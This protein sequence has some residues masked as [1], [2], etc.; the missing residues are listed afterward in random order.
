MIKI[1][2]SLIFTLFIGLANAQQLE[3]AKVIGNTSTEVCESTVV[4]AAGNIYSIGFFGGTVDFDSGAPVNELISAGGKDVYILKLDNAGEY[5]WAKSISSSGDVMGFTI[6]VGGISNDEIYIGGTFEGMADFDSNNPGTNTVTSQGLTDGFILK[7]NDNGDFQWVKEYGSFGNEAIY[8]LKL[9]AANQLYS[10]GAFENTINFNPGNTPIDLI[11]NPGGTDVFVMKH[12]ISDNLMWVKRFGGASYNDKGT[13]ITFD[14][15][16]NVIVAGEFEGTGNFDPVGNFDMISNG[17]FDVFI[18]KFAHD[19]DWLWAKNIGGPLNELDPKIEANGPNDIYITGSYQGTADFDPSAAVNNITSAGAHDIYVATLNQSG[20]LTAVESFGGTGEDYSRGID[21]S[22]TNEVYI[23]GD[24]ESTVNFNNAGGT[25]ELTSAGQNDAFVLKLNANLSIDWAK[26]FGGISEQKAQSIYVDNNN[27]VY[28]SGFAKGVTDF[29]PFSGITNIP[30]SSGSID[31]FIMK[32]A[33]C[34]PVYF[35]DAQSDCGSYTWTN[36]IEYT[37]DNSVATQVFESST[38]CDSIVILNLEVYPLPSVSAGAN[39]STCLGDNSTLS[40]TGAISYTWD[41]IDDGLTPIDGNG[42]IKVVP[43]SFSYEVTG[44]A[45]NGC[46]NVDTV[47][48]SIIPL[49]TFTVTPINTTC[50][51]LT[52]GSLTLSGLNSNASYQLVY[53][54]SVSGTTNAGSI[55][56]NGSGQIIV[57]GLAAEVFTNLTITSQLTGCIGTD[58]GSYTINDATPITIVQEPNIE[59]CET[60][61][62]ITINGNASGGA[63]GYSYIFNNGITSGTAFTPSLGSTTY[64]LIATDANSCTQSGVYQTV[65]IEATP[66]FTISSS[67]PTTCNGTDGSITLSGLTVSSA[68]DVSYQ[69]DNG[70]TSVGPTSMTTNASGDL[71]IP[72]LEANIFDGFTIVS[73]GGC[74]GDDLTTIITLADPTP[75]TVDAGLPQTICTGD[76][77]TLIA[78]SGTG[79]VITWDNGVQDGVGFIPTATTTYTATVNDNGCTAS[80][81]V[82]IILIPVDD[83]SFNYSATDYC[84]NDVNQL[85]TV[86][87]MG[88][89]FSGIASVNSATGEIDLPTT[90]QGIKVITHTTNGTC[91]NSYTQTIEFHTNPIISTLDATFCLNNG[92]FDLSTLST[93]L[94]GTYSGQ[95]IQNNLFI[96]DLALAI[97]YTYNYSFT[98]INGC[99]ASDFGNLMVNPIPEINLNIINTTCGNSTGSVDAT[100]T[101]GTAPYSIVWSTGQTSEDLTAVL[102]SNYYIN[103]TDDN[104]C[105]VMDVATVSNTEIELSGTVTN[106]LCHGNQNGSIN[107]TVTGTTG[108]Y[109]YYWSNGETTEDIS[110]LTSGQYEVFVTDNSNCTSTLSF[111]VTQ[112]NTLGATF[113]NTNPTSCGANNGNIVTTVTGGSLVYTFNWLDNTNTS[114]G[115]NQD[116]LAVNGRVYTLNIEDDN[117]CTFSATSTLTDNG[118]PN[119][120]L[121]QTTDASCLNN[122]ALNININST[123]AIQSYLW[124]NGEVTEDITN[125][126]PDEY[127]IT[128]TDVNNCQS[129]FTT[130]VMPIIPAPTDICL[131]TVDTSTNTNLV[132]WEKIVTSDIDYYVVFRETSVANEFLPVDTIYYADPSQFTDP[133]AYPQ[134]RSW[135]YKI[136]SVNTCGYSSYFGDIHKTMHVTISTGLAGTYNINWDEYEGFVYPTFDIWRYTNADG[137]GTNPIQSIPNTQFS[138]TDTPPTINGLDYIIEITPPN[139][140]TSTTNKAIDHNS[141]RSNKASSTAPGAGNSITEQTEL[142]VDIYPN[143]STGVFNIV[144]TNNANKTLKLYD[145][146]GSLVKEFISSNKSIQIDLNQFENGMYILEIYT[147]N[148][149]TRKQLLKQ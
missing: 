70:V 98:D 76:Q 17:N 56:T 48:I 58:A 100:V 31:A 16:N 9:D 92:D 127:T 114:I 78:A 64:T 29:D 77:V 144:L 123:V 136:K 105:Y 35:T 142:K 120:V 145:M 66:T 22:S 10:T 113:T 5:L 13:S 132:V 23:T 8:S 126:S 59:A 18:S 71:I 110:N 74:I 45:A 62:Q 75:P 54:G 82:Q 21:L 133:V 20:V 141:S 131:V 83:A 119:I 79:S 44:I 36:G 125:L 53:T 42:F 81:A 32:L 89:T 122:G 143:P 69:K 87:T 24:Y 72:G 2:I 34:T 88:G 19:G 28:V 93:P 116:L 130:T 3:W 121:N 30:T 140:C 84:L 52:D 148:S 134:F 4:D 60:S 94:G 101:N 102:S 25:Y 67:N 117:G 107:L 149:L 47:V 26:S 106:N 96:T 39:F 61:G 27:D 109:L 85:P 129:Y 73:T 57:T 138:L 80:D 97:P 91:P 38:G 43:G 115:T 14:S 12:D 46:Q 112:P 1:V 41:G 51:G 104:L 147:D 95:N 15:G 137:W 135:R 63:G 6:A 103:V 90:T 128:V 86:M 139:T 108:P 50:N 146:K 37:A 40:G 7:L 118:G 68:Y 33:P 99:S 111:N 55:L 49:P 11:A 65:I 124:S